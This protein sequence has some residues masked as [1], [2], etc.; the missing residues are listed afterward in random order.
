MEQLPRNKKKLAVSIIL[1]TMLVM[2]LAT[3]AD[4]MFTRPQRILVAL[5]LFFAYVVA[6][7]LYL[8]GVREEKKAKTLESQRF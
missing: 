3:W 2:L 4:H 7:V 6:L 8:L 5:A 1:W